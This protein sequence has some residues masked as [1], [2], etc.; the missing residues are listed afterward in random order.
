MPD[1]IEKVKKE[2]NRI[3]GA[4]EQECDEIVKM[5]VL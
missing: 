3:T 1:E 4:D 2:I 5:F